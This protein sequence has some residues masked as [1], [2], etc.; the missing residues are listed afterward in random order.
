MGNIK[1][2]VCTVSIQDAINAEKS[3]ADR[4]ELNSALAYGGL[5]PGITTLKK[6]K[7]LI[8]IPVMVMIRPRSGGFC[9]SELEFELMKDEL[10]A[11]IEAGA[12]GVVFGIL[13]ENSEIDYKRN[14]ILQQI[15]AP[16]T[17]V[18]HRAFDITPDPLSALDKLEEIGFD[19]VLTSAQVNKVEN[20]LSLAQKL[21]DYSKDKIDIVLCGGIRKHN[22]SKIVQNTNTKEIHFSAFVEKEDLSM[23]DKNIKFN[24]S[25]L[26]EAKYKVISESKVLAIKNK[27]KD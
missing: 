19:R 8:N 22:V 23:K 18:F 5:T 14:K 12:D 10:K 24:V 11:V 17:T 21:V 15:A 6:V 27:L 3:G 1:I 4:I 2:E 25:C 13:N 7:E 9:Y 20:N 16:V 26:P